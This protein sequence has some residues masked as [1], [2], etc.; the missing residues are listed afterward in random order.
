MDSSE[1]TASCFGKEWLFRLLQEERGPEQLRLRQPDPSISS[2]TSC[3]SGKSTLQWPWDQG[4]MG[5]V[6]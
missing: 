2:V 6:S 3:W 4:D 1:P 5:Q